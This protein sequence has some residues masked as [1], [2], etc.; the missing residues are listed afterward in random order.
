MPDLNFKVTH[1]Y[2]NRFWGHDYTITEVIDGGKKLRAMGW[3]LGIRRK[4]FL[5]LQNK[6]S[7][8]GVTRYQVDKIEYFDDPRDMWR[9]ILRHAPRQ[10]PAL[11]QKPTR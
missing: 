6:E 7:S 5:M 4:H 11:C 9:A 8:N 10:E 2:T 1:D 3:G